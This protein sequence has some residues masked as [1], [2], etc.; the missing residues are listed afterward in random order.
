MMHQGDESAGLDLTFEQLVAG[1]L[2]D[3][4]LHGYRAIKS[5][6]RRVAQ[7]RRRSSAA[8][9]PRLR[10]NPRGAQLARGAGTARAGEV[11]LSPRRSRIGLLIFVQG[12][13]GP[14]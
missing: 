6:R 12:V 10:R 4:E 8:R 3:Y 5:A 13:R 1:Y 2:E 9:L 7:L 11:M 14:G